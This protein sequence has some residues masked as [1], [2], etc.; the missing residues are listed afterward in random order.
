MNSFN[1]DFYEAPTVL[2]VG[3]KAEGIICSSE[4]EAEGEGFISWDE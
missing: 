1:K 4:I 3:V 2:V